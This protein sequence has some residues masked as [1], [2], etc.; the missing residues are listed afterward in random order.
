MAIRFQA[1]FSSGRMI[2]LFW[3]S[4]ASAAG[5]AQQVALT[6]SE[7][8]LVRRLTELL[9]GIGLEYR[10][11]TDPSL[12]ERDLPPGLRIG[13]PE[14]FFDI[15]FPPRAGPMICWSALDSAATEPDPLAGPSARTEA[16]PRPFRKF[17]RKTTLEN[18]SA[19]AA[20]QQMQNAFGMTV[21]LDCRIDPGRAGPGP[22]E[23]DS[24]QD[25]LNRLER[26][27]RW[28]WHVAEQI[29]LL[30]PG[31]ADR[32]LGLP[33][34]GVRALIYADT[35]L[36]VAVEQLHSLFG[37]EMELPPALAETKVTGAFKGATLASCSRDYADRRI[38]RSG[39][40]GKVVF[41]SKENMDR[42]PQPAPLPSGERNILL[43]VE[44]LEVPSKRWEEFNVSG[45][46]S[47]MPPASFEQQEEFW[48]K[49]ERASG[50]KVFGRAEAIVPGGSEHRVHFPMAD[51]TDQQRRE[52]SGY[53]FLL[54]P[55]ISPEGVVQIDARIQYRG[56]QQRKPEDIL[57]RPSLYEQPIHAQLWIES[58]KRALLHGAAREVKKGR[59]NYFLI[60]IQPT[61]STQ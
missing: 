17:A 46:L 22:I 26:S 6:G 13:S 23:A 59:K 33:N 43:R 42:L 57:L 35:P 39:R 29:V 11:T 15:C 18:V 1:F 14:T 10:V 21:L 4:V 58:G 45:F 20:A 47:S 49:V 52:Q 50:V 54:R 2:I 55:A 32:V 53:L 41:G 40:R 19:L 27:E 9:Q 5:F 8:P 3:M 12:H 28:Q 34:R 61:H 30:M 56:A 38:A 48:R 24:L 36:S 25:A 31:E 60:S 44:V 16:F 37:I 7:T 51:V